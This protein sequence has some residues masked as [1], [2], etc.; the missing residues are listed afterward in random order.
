MENVDIKIDTNNTRISEKYNKHD[1]SIS[2]FQLVT[3]HVVDKTV[4]L[5][6]LQINPVKNIIKGSY[7][8][9]ML[10][11]LPNDNVSYH[12]MRCIGLGSSIA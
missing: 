6:E 10:V 8:I 2:S 12:N 5:H 7:S 9:I 1:I 3:L 11:L 4:S